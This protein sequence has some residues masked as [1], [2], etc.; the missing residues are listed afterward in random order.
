MKMRKIMDFKKDQLLKVIV[1]E[2]ILTAAPVGSLN[3]AEQYRLPS[4]SATLRNWMSDLE[5][6]GYLKQPYPSSGRIPTDQGYRHYVTLLM[7]KENL[8][9]KTQRLIQKELES[10]FREIED[11]ITQAAK[12]ISEIGKCT[13]L[14]MAPQKQSLRLDSLQLVSIGKERTLLVLVTDS[15]TIHDRILDLDIPKEQLETISNI[16]NEKLHGC[17]IADIGPHLIEGVAD[18]MNLEYLSKI[19][20][21]IGNM[22]EL[23]NKNHL[24]VEG[25]HHL[26]D[27]PE[28]Q[29]VN[30]LKK[31]FEAFQNGKQISQWLGQVGFAAPLN[32]SIG[33][34]NP[35]K[36][37]QEFSII[38]APYEIEG[39][40]IGTLALV[41]PTRMNYDQLIPLVEYS[42]SFLSERFS[43]RIS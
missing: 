13:I 1:K 19:V 16:L 32:I 2:Y 5:L 10:G 35:F 36:E 41:G 31:S 8:S 23:E 4:S 38:A 29:D 34:E 39:N 9:E 21:L 11:L 40:W 3:L 25:A 24:I 33:N 28:F 17:P 6:S 26:F 7:D 37:F 20:E 18:A 27:Q 42:A 43:R 15:E 22:V 14:A 12:I 30:K